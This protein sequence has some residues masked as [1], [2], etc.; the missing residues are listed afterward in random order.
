MDVFEIQCGSCQEHIEIDASMAGGK[1]RCPHCKAVI[2]LPPLEELAEAYEEEVEEDSGGALEH[3]EAYEE[4]EEDE[5]EEEEDDEEDDIP[6]V[7][8]RAPE[9]KKAPAP[10]SKKKPATPRSAQAGGKGGRRAEKTAVRRREK[11]AVRRKTGP[12]KAGAGG[13]RPSGSKLPLLLA[14]G[15]VVVVLIVG[16]ILA[17]SFL[18]GGSPS[19]GGDGGGDDGPVT[20]VSSNDDG[21]G[22]SGGTDAPADVD[23][24]A[25]PSDADGRVTY[26]VPEDLQEYTLEWDLPA[27]LAEAS[28]T[29]VTQER[30][31]ELKE[32]EDRFRTEIRTEIERRQD[33]FYESVQQAKRAYLTRPGLSQLEFEVKPAKPY[34]VFEHVGDK[35]QPYR[36]PGPV[37]ERKLESK[38]RMLHKAFDEVT[39][40]WMKPFGFTMDT[41]LPLSV[42][43]LRDRKAFDQVNR[44]FGMS[45][46]PGALAYF[47]PV[48]SYIILY[49]DP[50]GGVG[51]QAK[52]ESD[53]T[54][55]HEATHQVLNAFVNKGKGINSTGYIH[56]PFWVNEGMAEY[57]GSVE[58]T[59]EVDADG[60]DVY[61]VGVPNRGRL[62]EFWAARHPPKRLA[63]PPYFLDLEGLIECFDRDSIIAQVKR[64]VGEELKADAANNPKWAIIEQICISMIYA[65]ASSFYLFCYEYQNGKYASAM[66]AYLKK[67]FRGHYHTQY[68][69]EAFGTSDLSAINK[70]W[71]DYVESVTPDRIKQRTG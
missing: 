63:I 49:N 5:E 39:R 2:Q 64:K 58:I 24:P 13:G 35:G 66:D 18:G 29:K 17:A 32:I 50:M 44:A 56:I 45:L 59:G 36:D 20:D 53:G 33:P 27:E 57:I 25:P 15:V 48:H 68:F 31:R 52:A 19:G 41:D 71:L 8:V 16:L 54:V 3:E 11:T 67:A 37:A 46:P 62:A 42:F 9:R 10:P 6:E 60:Y 65:Q 28:G 1:V 69:H 43:A 21:D 12:L 4:E 14:A 34:V 22:G 70:E 55:F 47:S 30:Y 23:T 51:L 61:K 7:P 38:L 40:R 26:E